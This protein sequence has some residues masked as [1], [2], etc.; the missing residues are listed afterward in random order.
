[1]MILLMEEI[2]HL[3]GYGI[4]YLSTGAGCFPSTVF[5]Q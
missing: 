5:D 2:L 4:N 1:M 3:L